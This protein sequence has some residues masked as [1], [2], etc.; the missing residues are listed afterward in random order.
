[1]VRALTLALLAL[2]SG[3][4]STADVAT[5]SA[6][7]AEGVVLTLPLP[8]A[9]PDTRTILQ[10]GYA[11]Y[12]DHDGAFEAVLSLAPERTEIVM[13]M[14]GGPRL[15]T[16]VWDSVGVRAERSAFAPDNVP[17]EN[18][19]VDIFITVWPP[20][21]VEAALPEGLVLTVNEAGQRTIRRGDEV[22]MTV[23]PDPEDA[24]RVSIRNNALGYEVVIVSQSVE[25]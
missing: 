9:Y 20:A 10:T 24:A 8:P 25:P 16:I 21:L 17:V 22:L 5:P 1:M 3:C 13:T 15:A 11:R 4:A 2:A 23:T 18:I 14:L 19:L 7:I 12:G 6:H